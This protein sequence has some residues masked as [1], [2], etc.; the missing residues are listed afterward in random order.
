MRVLAVVPDLFFASKVAATAAALGATLEQP[1]LAEAAIWCRE[2][3]PDLVILDLGSTAA[4][5]LAGTLKADAATRDI[6]IVGF[7]SH[8]EAA[9]RLAALAAGVDQVLPRPAFVAKLPELLGA[10]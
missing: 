5:E 10:G 1:P 9:T 7:Y 4:I 8:V 6:P 3:A 2:R